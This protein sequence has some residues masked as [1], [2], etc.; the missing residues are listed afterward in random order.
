VR[1]DGTVESR[2]IVVNR[3]VGAD[4]VVERGLSPGEEVV[5]DGQIR[6]AP[7]VRVQDKS[8]QPRSA[9]EARP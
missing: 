3:T 7:G 5:T 9:P 1:A 2:P 6:I 8:G 4:A